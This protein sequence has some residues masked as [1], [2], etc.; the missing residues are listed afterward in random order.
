MRR[1]GG[2]LVRP[3]EERF[4]D[5]YRATKAGCWEWRGCVNS[6][7]YGC[8]SFGGK[9]RSVLAHRWAYERH[10]GPIP[11]GLT[12][13]HLCRNRRCVNPAHLEPVT[14]GENVRRG[15]A[16][17]G[18]YERQEVWRRRTDELALMLKRAAMARGLR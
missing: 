3:A 6:R 14:V 9:G 17:V 16:C 15:Q 12:L 2:G 8:F 7:G 11:D 13:D 10:V 5:L 4:A 18:T 1:R